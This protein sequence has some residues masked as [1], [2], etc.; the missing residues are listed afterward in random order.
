[1]A[2]R[3]EPSVAPLASS[4]SV[5]T[6]TTLPPRPPVVNLPNPSAPGKAGKL[7]AI[8]GLTWLL[9]ISAQRQPTAAIMNRLVL[10]L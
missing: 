8:A 5:V 3:S 2:Q 7:L 4:A 9:A 1:M 6:Y 10:E